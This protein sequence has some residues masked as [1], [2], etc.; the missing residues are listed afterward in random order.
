MTMNECSVLCIG[1]LVW[2]LFPDRPRMGGAPFNVA[3]HLARQGVT[4]SLLTAV[5]RDELGSKSLSF[6]EREGIPG[7]LTHP[8][9]PTGTVKVELDRAGVP[10]FTV[11][12]HAAWTDVKG[13]FLSGSPPLRESL[14]LLKLAV[15][16]FGGL[17]MHSPANRLLFSDFVMEFQKSGRPVPL[18]LCDLNLRPRLVRSR[19]RS[20]VC[21]PSGHPQGQRG[22]T[23]VPCKPGAGIR[24]RYGPRPAS[25]ICPPGPLYDARPSRLAMVRSSQCRSPVPCL[26]RGRGSQRNRH[27]RRGGCHHRVHRHGP[28]PEGISHYLP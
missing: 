6:L 18:R 25:P 23:P 15:I 8:K 7:A 10:S 13:A 24:R 1:E 12:N 16:V 17:A 4:V 5:G 26:V 22:G 20:L 2:D 27:R 11:Q 19:G 21:G 14:D 28:L 3:V 9:L